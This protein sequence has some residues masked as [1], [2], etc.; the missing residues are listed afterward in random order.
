M[1]VGEFVEKGDSAQEGAKEV[2]RVTEAVQ[3]E[4]D[5]TEGDHKEEEMMM[6]EDG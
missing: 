1:E 6:E 4:V 2:D 3:T 5:D